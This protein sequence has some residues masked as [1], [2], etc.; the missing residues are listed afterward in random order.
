M[1]YTNYNHIPLALAVMLL[2][3]EYDYN[4]TEKT[5]STTTLLDTPKQ[6]ILSQRLKGEG[7]SDVSD[8]IDTVLGTS[9]HATLEKA[10][11]N[12]Y[13]ALEDLD[14]PQA[15]RDRICI[16]PDIVPLI[17]GTIPIYVEQRASKQI[18]GWTVTGKF[19]IIIDGRLGDLKSRKAWAW[20]HQSNKQKDILQGSIYRWLNQDKI[21]A[22]DFSIYW[23]IKNWDKLESIKDKTYPQNIIIDQKL[24]LKSIDETEQYLTQKL[25]ILDKYWNSPEEDIPPCKENSEELWM[26]PPVWK[27]YSKPE[28]T[29]CAKGGTYSTSQE[30]YTRLHKEGNVGKVVE[31]KSKATKCSWC[32][33]SSICNQYNDLVNQ[34]LI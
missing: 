28:N 16:N 32:S 21:T 1:K 19:D 30:A 5:I 24:K 18:V 15:I 8:K 17:K 20:K 3:D 26:N 31:I 4:H 2:S 25:N 7:S 6:I 27:Y 23:F 14:Y 12:P 33:A 10:W 29:S 34:G 13:K 22:E 9:L 11:L